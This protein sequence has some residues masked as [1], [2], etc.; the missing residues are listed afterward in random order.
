MFGGVLAGNVRSV[1]NGRHITG[2]RTLR[3]RGHTSERRLHGL[4]SSL[5]T[6]VIISKQIYTHSHVRIKVRIR[7][8]ISHFS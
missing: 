4:V 8:S 7:I 6:V 1:C 3:M 2:L 5:D